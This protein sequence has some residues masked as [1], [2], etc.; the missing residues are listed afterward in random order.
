[1]S[2][3]EV[4]ELSAVVSGFLAVAPGWGVAQPREA[5]G[6]LVRRGRL[7]MIGLWVIYI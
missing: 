1:V 5:S 3:S 4:S 2:Q 7:I 6:W